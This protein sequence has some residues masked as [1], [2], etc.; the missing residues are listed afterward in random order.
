MD[1][2]QGVRAELLAAIEAIR[3]LANVFPEW[4]SSAAVDKAEIRRLLQ[5][6]ER[7]LSGSDDPA[8]VDAARQELIAVMMATTPR[9]EWPKWGWSADERPPAR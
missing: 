1:D 6:A 3:L 8:V 7:R 9:E 5:S 4:L 2:I